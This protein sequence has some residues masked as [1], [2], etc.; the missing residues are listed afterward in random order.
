MIYAPIILFVYNRPDL[1]QQTLTSLMCNAEAA[2]SR[3]FVFSDGPKANA[4][5]EQKAKIAAVRAVINSRTWC[6]ETTLIAAESNKGLANSVIAG[7]TRIVN[8]FGKAIIVEDDVMLSPYFLQFMN[9][10]LTYYENNDKVA[11]IGGWNYYCPPED[12]KNH[13]F[14]R[15]PDT[16]AWATWARAWQLSNPDTDYLISEIKKQDLGKYLNMNNSLNLVRML[17]QQK[18]GK[19][20]SW[21]VRWTASLV[22]NEKLSLY[23]QFPLT[24]HE[25]FAAGTHFSAHQSAEE[26]PLALAQH[27]LSMTPIVVEENPLAVHYFTKHHRKSHGIWQR[28]VSTLRRL[29]KY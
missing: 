5:A 13:F 15:H 2:K 4:T 12:I 10:A 6:A 22:L 14:L 27:P 11:S 18:A 29:L 8:E 1:T 20:D 26:K 16:I 21:A 25:G 7:V 3:L 17:H 23:P 24:R 9:E 28:A 19:V